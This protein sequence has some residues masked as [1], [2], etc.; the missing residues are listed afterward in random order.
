MIC[1]Y[2]IHYIGCLDPRLGVS[3]KLSVCQTCNLKLTECAGHFGYIHLALPVFHIGYFKH[4]YAF[5]QCICKTCSRILLMEHDRESV[6]KKMRNTS[7]DNLQR[8]AVFSKLHAKCKK[9]KQCPY[10]HAVVG[11]VKK[12][13]GV[14]TLKLIHERYTGR[15][16]ENELDNLIDSMQ[17]TLDLNK[18]Q[19]VNPHFVED[20]HAVRVLEL[21]KKISDE[22]CVVLGMNPH[23]GRPENLVIE[24]VS[25]PPVAIRPSVKMDLGGGSNEDDL[26][27]QLQEII[28]VN[29]ALELALGKGPASK[30]I[31]ESWDILQLEVAKYINAD[32]PGIQKQMG[33]KPVRGLC[34]RLKGKQ[35]R[36]RGNLSGKRVDFSARTVI[37]PDPNLSIHQVGVPVHV[38]KIMTFP[39]SVN[40]YNINHLR[41]LVR[42]GP[43]VHPGANMIRMNNGM[44]KSLAFAGDLNKVA[45]TLKIGDVVERHMK[46]GDFVLFNRQPSLHRL[47]IM[48]HEVKVMPWRTFRFNIQVC[49]PYNADF[50]GDEMNLHLIQT[51]EARSEAKLLMG[52]VNNLVTPRNGEPLISSAQ[53]YLTCSYMLTQKDQFFSRYV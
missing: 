27:V 33:N 22:D 5:L 41:D 20:M 11:A 29:V 13:T 50:D 21:F 8:E 37:S 39:E 28:N 17:Y 30:M 51:H 44:V 19:D 18:N 16:C 36:F 4:I 10:C 52:T 25:V 46:D 47:S 38:A 9:A 15:H 32:M 45:L 2:R 24:M 49:A 23:A 48:C 7:L 34:Q 40:R 53:D 12:L 43:D 42:N 35:G 31:I 1:H 14:P 3:D 6:L 26:T